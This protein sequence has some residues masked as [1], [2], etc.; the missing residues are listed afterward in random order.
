MRDTPA[1]IFSEG[2]KP[3]MIA[4]CFQLLS[5]QLSHRYQQYLLIKTSVAVLLFRQMRVKE[6]SCARRE[7]SGK[8]G[9][10][11]LFHQVAETSNA[12]RARVGGGGG[13]GSTVRFFWVYA[14]C[15]SEPPLPHYI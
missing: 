2:V 10:D 6:T 5:T 14:A 13:G 7:G 15:V 8:A 3:L 11:V 12:C 9:Q 1:T 4:V